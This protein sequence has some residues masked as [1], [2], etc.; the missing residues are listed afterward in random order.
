M[1]YKKAKACFFLST[2]VLG[3][4]ASNLSCSAKPAK[5]KLIK[6][7]QKKSINIT[8]L[9]DGPEVGSILSNFLNKIK[10]LAK[11]K[12]GA[13]LLPAGIFLAASVAAAFVYYAKKKNLQELPNNSCIEEKDTDVNQNFEPDDGKE[14]DS[15]A[16]KSAGGNAD[17][18]SENTVPKD[19]KIATKEAPT[20][21]NLEEKDNSKSHE[22][23]VNTNGGKSGSEVD[24]F[25]KAFYNNIM[26]YTKI[27]KWW[28]FWSVLLFS[29]GGALLAIIGKILS[30]FCKILGFYGMNIG[31]CIFGFLA[32]F[33]TFALDPILTILKIPLSFKVFLEGVIF[34]ACA[35]IF[36]AM[37]LFYLSAF[38]IDNAR[39]AMKGKKMLSPWNYIFYIK[40]LV[41]FNKLF[42]SLGESETGRVVHKKEVIFNKKDPSTFFNFYNKFPGDNNKDLRATILEAFTALHDTETE[43]G[44][45]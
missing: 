44:T 19:E 45:N 2:L 25:K 8:N 1:N 7:N 37:G 32:P 10:V 14:I 40:F 3:F 35:A 38:I 6:Q 22:N 41:D 30:L 31:W 17:T 39:L 43:N 5:G 36:T 4:S 28:C 16:T 12:P 33:L 13:I 27:A 24:F 21:T 42:E 29:W 23:I 11:E 26:Y 20:D 18:N 34:S 15:S 9:K